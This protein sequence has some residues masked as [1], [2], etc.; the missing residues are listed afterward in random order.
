MDS[1]MY[2][3]FSAIAKGY[4]VDVVADYLEAKA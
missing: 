4:A 1:A 2:L 3:D